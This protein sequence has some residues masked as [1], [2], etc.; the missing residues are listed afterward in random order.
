[1]KAGSHVVLRASARLYAPLIVLFALSLLATRVAGAGVGLVAGLA[2]TLALILHLLVFGV[3]EARR[4][5]PEFVSSAMVTLGLLA[6]LI[7]GGAPRLLYAPQIIEAGL[8]FIVVGG[9]QLAI[10]VLAGRAPTLRD[11]DW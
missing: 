11:E 8:F 1:M 5:I 9:A 7:A 2:A 6:A 3:A 4:A 10:V